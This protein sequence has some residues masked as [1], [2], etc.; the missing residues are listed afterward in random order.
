[1]CGWENFSLSHTFVDVSFMQRCFER[2]FNRF[3]TLCTDRP[4]LHVQHVQ[5]L[6]KRESGQQR[7]DF[8]EGLTLFYIGHPSSQRS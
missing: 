5:F 4:I 7:T 6:C 3:A 1:M 8:C 2:V